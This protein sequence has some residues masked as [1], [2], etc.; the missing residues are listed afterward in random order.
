M[1]ALGQALSQAVRLA[2]EGDWRAAHAI[3][4]R[5]EGDAQADWIHAVLH[6]IEGDLDN[7]R[8][9]Y[10]RC[11]RSLEPSESPQAEL[12]RIADALGANKKSAARRARRPAQ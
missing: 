1:S 9:W 7:A 8:Y 4:Q 12:A 5:H 6:R 11:G 3:V 2:R 10:R